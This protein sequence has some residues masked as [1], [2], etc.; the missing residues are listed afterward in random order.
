V[1]RCPD[2]YRGVNET[3]ET[4]AQDVE[5]AAAKLEAKGNKVACFIVES[6]MSVGGALT[7]LA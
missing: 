6:G 1:V 5:V 4:Y 3:A 2:M 7:V